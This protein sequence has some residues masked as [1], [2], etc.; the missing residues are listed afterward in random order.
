M[1]RA[2]DGDGNGRGRSQPSPRIRR[3]STSAPNHATIPNRKSYLFEIDSEPFPS[4]FYKGGRTATLQLEELL[5][6]RAFNFPKDASLGRG[7]FGTMGM[8]VLERAVTSR[9]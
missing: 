6:R 4:V 8:S 3:G 2:V 1:Q 7:T 5:G 9:P